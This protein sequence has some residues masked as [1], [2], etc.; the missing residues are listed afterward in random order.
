MEYTTQNLRKLIL[1]WIIENQAIDDIYFYDVTKIINAKEQIKQENVLKQRLYAKISHEF[2]TPLNSIIGLVT[3]IEEAVINNDKFNTSKYLRYIQS[4]SRYVIYLTNDIIRYSSCSDKI[5]N[6][7]KIVKNIVN[8][9][10]I[11]K[12]AY[13]ILESL[14]KCDSNKF[15]SIKL[16]MNY[17]ID[18]NN[19]II[20]S[21]EIR[22]EQILLNF[23]SNAVKFTN[24]GLISVDAKYDSDSKNVILSVS[25]TGIGVFHEHFDKLFKEYTQINNNVNNN[26]YGTGIGLSVCKSISSLID[27]K[28][29]FSSEYGLGSTFS[30]VIPIINS[31]IQIIDKVILI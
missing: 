31:P 1:R 23:I 18:I 2:K 9:K 11:I 15:E 30:L 12:F 14:I 3:N 8:I 7:I 10:D 5:E 29:L 25:D 6:C 4:L 13:E 20:Y 16:M 21:D 28:I 24:S 27:A 19:L 17:D 22:I 26:Q